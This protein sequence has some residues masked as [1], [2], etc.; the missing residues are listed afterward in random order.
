MKTT[1]IETFAYTF[2]HHLPGFPDTHPC[3]G[4]HG[5]TATITIT[6]EVEH[7]GAYAFDRAELAEVG[8]D[9]T[10]KVDHRLINEVPGL[11]DGL[12]ESQLRWLVQHFEAALTERWHAKLVRAELDE[13]SAENAR[14][15]HHRMV[16]SAESP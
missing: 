13:F 10:R 3:H 16:W 11:E 5:H 1:F 2:A 12:A 15:V 8:K 14:L 4:L 6:V 9:V 7:G